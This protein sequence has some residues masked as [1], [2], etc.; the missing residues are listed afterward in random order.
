MLSAAVV[1]VVVVSAMLYE[2][3]LHED[4]RRALNNDLAGLE[5]DQIAL[6][7]ENGG[8]SHRGWLSTGPGVATLMRKI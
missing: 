6:R 4:D 7:F 1:V 8:Q 5:S 2:R 3:A